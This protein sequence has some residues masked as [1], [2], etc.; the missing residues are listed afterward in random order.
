[1]WERRKGP[2]MESVDAPI[3][4]GEEKGAG[5]SREAERNTGGKQ[6]SRKHSPRGTSHQIKG[7]KHPGRMPETQKDATRVAALMVMPALPVC[8]DVC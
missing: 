5:V 3:F 1:M 6:K 7:A 8:L 2:R 4:K